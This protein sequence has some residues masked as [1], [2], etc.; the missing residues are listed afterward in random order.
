MRITPLNEI[1]GCTIEGVALRSANEDELRQIHTAWMQYSVVVIKNQKLTPSEQLR[2]ASYFGSPD[3]YPFLE[4]LE[5][6]PEI[7]LK[8][9]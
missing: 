2:F 6:H 3:I 5:G 1:V 7:F 9:V 4:G 8:H